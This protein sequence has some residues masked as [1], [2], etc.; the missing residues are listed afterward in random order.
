[1][2]NYRSP[3]LV[4][5]LFTTSSWAYAITPMEEVKKNLSDA[6]YE[7]ALQSLNKINPEA[8]NIAEY[9]FLKGK[10]E[11]GVYK[12]MEAILS[13][14]KSFDNDSTKWE[15]LN[16]MAECYQLIGNYKKATNLYASLLLK[17][18]NNIQLQLNAANF[19][20]AIENYKTSIDIYKKLYRIDSTNIYII[21]CMSKCYDNLKE[22]EKAI[23]FYQKAIALNPYDAQSTNRLC[24]MYIALRKYDE[25][26]KI[27]EI[28]QRKDS[29]NQR[30]NSTNAFIY[31]LKKNYTE[32]SIRFG[33]CCKNKDS[34][35]FTLK[36][37]GIS[38][39]N[40]KQFEEAKNY[41]EKAFRIDSSDTQ[42]CN[43]LGLSCYYSFYKLQAINYMKK[44]VELASPDSSY[45]ASLYFNLGQAYDGYDKS[46]CIDAYKAYERAYYLNPKDGKDLLYLAISCDRCAKDRENAIKY[47]K[48]FMSEY[49]KSQ[50]KRDKD[51]ATL[52]DNLYLSIE[53]RTKEL[54]KQTIKAK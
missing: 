30:I 3:F 15:S 20:N 7:E 22:N 27:T 37:L 1:M 26:I 11:K 35:F 33:N 42:T 32:A 41:L 31:Y 14:Q 43:Y 23:G 8:D 52:Y 10:A 53:K 38:C 34:T 19:F 44:S 28:Y 6:N 46:D 18:K 51:S 12:T 5:I 21:R 40:N 17:T 29:S 54:E 2:Q 4:A 45:L 47:Y 39:Y 50:N 9:Y 49:P 36:Y 25:A 16:E 13:F 24:N 48:K